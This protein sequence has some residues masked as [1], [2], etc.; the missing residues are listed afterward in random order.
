MLL[1]LKKL[2]PKKKLMKQDRYPRTI[3]LTIC[4][5]SEPKIHFD[6]WNVHSRL[7]SPIKVNGPHTLRECGENPYLNSLCYDIADPQQPASRGKRLLSPCITLGELPLAKYSLQTCIFNSFQDVP[8]KH[9]TS[10]FSL[11]D[12]EVWLITNFTKTKSS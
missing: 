4:F 9:W 5:L 11:T 8:K 6:D 2:V 12:Q 7:F 10:S 3:S 1:F